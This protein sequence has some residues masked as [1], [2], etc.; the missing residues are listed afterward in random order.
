MKGLGEPGPA[1]RALILITDGE[2]H[3]SFALDAARQAAEAGIKIIAI[4]FGDEAGSQIYITDPRTG[5]RT[6]LRDGAGDAVVSRLDGDMLREIALV[7]NGAYV[8]AG[9]GVLDLA[10]IY[11]EHIAGLTRSQLDSRGRSIRDDVYGWFV[12]LAMLCL[13]AAVAIAAGRGDAAGRARGASAVALLLAVQLVLGAARPSAAQ[14]LSSEDPQPS[15]NTLEAEARDD[16]P[17]DTEAPAETPAD[18]P[19]DGPEDAAAPAVSDETPR[20]LYNRATQS[21]ATANPSAVE[22]QLLDARRRAVDDPELRY[23]ATYNL[24]VAAVAR[25]EQVEPSDP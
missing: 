13:I 16:T 7:T 6:L 3:D 17:S 12:L 14:P 9:T 10:S 1:Q 11:Q 24:G 22:T 8:P 5:A 23:A 21:L 4:G 15:A 18:A 2:D 19:I 25:A 20:E